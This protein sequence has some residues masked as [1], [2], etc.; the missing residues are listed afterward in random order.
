M[1]I[2]PPRDS[3]LIGPPVLKK[4]ESAGKRRATK[5][6]PLEALHQRTTVAGLRTEGINDVAHGEAQ[7]EKLHG[8]VRS[9]P[10]SG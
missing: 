1:H 10:H 6:R 9:A 3:V 7:L 5:Q 2:E 4:A 8:R